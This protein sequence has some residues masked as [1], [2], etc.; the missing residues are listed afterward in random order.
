MK[1]VYISGP[2]RSAT[3][4]GVREN[5]EHAYQT[6]VT[7]HQAG[8]GELF[9]V[10][11]HLNTQFMDGVMPDNHWLTGDC[12]LLERCDAVLLEEDDRAF[13]V[14]TERRADHVHERTERA[15]EERS[16]ARAVLM[17]F[18]RVLQLGDPFFSEE[19]RRESKI[20]DILLAFTRDVRSEEG[21]VTEPHQVQ[22]KERDVGES[23]DRLLR[24][25]RLLIPCAGKVRE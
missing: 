16:L 8:K 19:L 1:L 17:D 18:D 5:I 25:P 7:M 11:P 6:A 13:E 10:V 14:R 9:P 15:A 3:M 24:I 4:N 23:N 22:Q 20:G 21:D 12:L 2:Y